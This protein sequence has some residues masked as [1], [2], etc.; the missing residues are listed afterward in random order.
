MERATCIGFAH[1]LAFYPRGLHSPKVFEASAK[2]AFFR[3]APP[4]LVFNQTG[5]RKRA[6]FGR[7]GSRNLLRQHASPWNVLVR[8][9][10]LVSVCIVF[11]RHLNPFRAGF[12]LSFLRSPARSCGRHRSTHP[13]PHGE[14]SRAGRLLPGLCRG[15]QEVGQLGIGGRADPLHP[16]D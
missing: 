10:F 15:A 9:K 4:P 6:C 16:M 2:V 12:L 5:F 8:F 1:V 11:P 14:A 7:L 13:G 3:R